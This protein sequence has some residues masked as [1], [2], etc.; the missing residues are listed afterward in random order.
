MEMPLDKFVDELADAMTSSGI[1]DLALTKDARKRFVYNMHKLLDVAAL[2]FLAKAHALQAE[3][4][5]L[6][7]DA[8]VLTDLRPVFHDPDEPPVDMIVE[9]TLKIIYHDGSRHQ[10]REIYMAMDSDDIT[11][12]K[13]ALE[14][15]EKKAASLKM[16]LQSKNL[17]Q[18]P[19]LSEAR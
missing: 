17:T 9:Y 16:L 6:F 12:L 14:R 8:K 18:M 15:A 7:R 11:H 1:H 10:H 5:R 2:S 4:E 19:S 3:H 13:E